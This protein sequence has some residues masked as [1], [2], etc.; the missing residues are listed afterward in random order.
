MHVEIAFDLAAFLSEQHWKQEARTKHLA[1][2]REQTRA[3]TGT[4]RLRRPAV[5]AQQL[6]PDVHVPILDRGESREQVALRCVRLRLC[7]KTIQIRRIG[8]VLP[9][10]RERVKIGSRLR[11]C[12]C[13]AGHA[14]KG[15]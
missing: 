9:M 2:R 10:M 13:G 7:E 1:E 5:L 3:R 11:W 8:L 4:E 6:A 14:R 12:G 15:K